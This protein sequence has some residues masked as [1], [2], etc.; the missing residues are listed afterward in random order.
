MQIAIGVVTGVV[1]S[2]I[3]ALLL[4][5]IRARRQSAA[6]PQPVAPGADHV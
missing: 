5:E 6:L 3:A 2:V 1:T 4:D